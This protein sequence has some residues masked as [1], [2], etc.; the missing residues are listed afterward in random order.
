MSDAIDVYIQF[1]TGNHTSVKVFKSH[2]LQ[3]ARIIVKILC[4]IGNL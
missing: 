4:T 2:H 3:K 1:I